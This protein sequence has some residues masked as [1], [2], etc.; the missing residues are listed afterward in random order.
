MILSYVTLIF[1]VII[2]GLIIAFLYI[3]DK[4]L[5]EDLNLLQEAILELKNQP[6]KE[7]DESSYKELDSKIYELGE[8][9]IKIVRSI[10]NLDINQIEMAE[11]VNKIEEQLKLSMITTDINDSEIIALFKDGKSIEDIAKEKRVPQRQVEFIIKLANLN[12]N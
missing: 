3:K 5:V 12:V 10:K 6:I 7:S 4:Q 11:R 8:S 1:L 2:L 9:L